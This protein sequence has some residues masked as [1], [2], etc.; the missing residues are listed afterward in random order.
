MTDSASAV[1]DELPA[2]AA[3]PPVERVAVEPPEA[4]KPSPDPEPEPQPE[5]KAEPT[6]DEIE[7]EKRAE[8][9][10]VILPDDNPRTWTIGQNQ[11]VQRQ[12]SFVRRLEFFAVVARALKSS[13]DQGGIGLLSDLLGGGSIAQRASQL[14]S[15]DLGEAMEFVQM[16]ASLVEYAPHLITDCFCVWLNVPD[17]QR[18]WVKAAWAGDL[19]EDGIQALTDDEAKEMIELFIVQNWEAI[20]TFFTGH[21]REIIEVAKKQREDA[22]DAE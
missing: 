16:A 1:V 18:G 11:Y 12:L 7:A 22:N 21:V 4:P 17:I 20:Q 3:A 19:E 14:T 15:S 13:L 6:P 8:E 9:S 2:V 5:A 10:K